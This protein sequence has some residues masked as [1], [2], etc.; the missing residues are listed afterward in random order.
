MSKTFEEMKAEVL[1]KVADKYNEI[2]DLMNNFIDEAFELEEA[3]T[4]EMMVSVFE[5]FI[6]VVQ[7][8]LESL[9][10][11]NFNKEECVEYVGKITGVEFPEPE[12]E[13]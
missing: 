2:I 6:S 3:P 11:T 7:G 1:G 5:D 13:S 9:G 8:K 12:L 4:D 10:V